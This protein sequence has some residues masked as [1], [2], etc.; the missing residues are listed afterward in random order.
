MPPE[1]IVLAAGRGTRMHS[2]L[3]KALHP[4]GGMPMLV[5]VLRAALE[6][7]PARIH[8]VIGQSNGAVRTAMESLFTTVS[9]RFNWVVQAEP[10]GTGD[11]V[12]RA[13]S[14]VDSRSRCLVLFGDVPLVNPHDLRRLC[15]AE[16]TLAILTARPANPSGLGRI[17]RD[18]SGNIQGIVEE[19]DATSEQLSIGEINT[20]VLLCEAAALGRWVGA[21]GRDNR[22]GEYYLTDI[23]ALAVADGEAVHGEIAQDPD[24]FMGINSRAE[25]AVAERGFQRLAAGTLMDAGVTLM[26]PERVDIRGEARFGRDCVVDVNVV[27]EG[28]VEVGDGVT[29]GPGCVIRDTRI[30][31]HCRIHPYSVLEGAELGSHCLVGPYARLRPETRLDDEVRVGNFVEVKK[32]RLARGSKANHLAYI[33][34]STVGRKSN[35]GAGVITCNYDGAGKHRTEIGDDV[36]VGSDSQLVAPV[37]IADGVTIGAGSTITRD[38]DQPALVVSRAKQVSYPGWKRPARKPDPK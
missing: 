3:P 8:I 21:I 35:I 34:D 14:D 20:G 37:R 26:D 24:R 25:L 7:E 36:F 16:S 18:S 33:G 10:R 17:L 11:A 12:R 2:D 6:L 13:M 31:D 27:L 4:V 22:Q 29:I 19:K 5:H 9:D 23:V 15:R 30:G 38:V 1:V 28:L 32:S